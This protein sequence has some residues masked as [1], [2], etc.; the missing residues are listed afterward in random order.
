VTWLK[1]AKLQQKLTEPT[2][3]TGQL[4]ASGDR[5]DEAE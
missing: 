3:A 2:T 1:N 5:S 4:K